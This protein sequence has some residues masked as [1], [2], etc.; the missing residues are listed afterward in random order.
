MCFA[1]WLSQGTL[2][3]L[4]FIPRS[5]I[6]RS[7]AGWGN[8]KRTSEL[9]NYWTP[10]TSG[11]D[12]ILGLFENGRS[13]E[14]LLDLGLGLSKT[15]LPKMLPTLSLLTLSYLTLCHHELISLP[16]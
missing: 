12:L 7:L 10:M 3:T 5:L 4:L 14:W 8:A 2:S 13:A 16:K 11:V 9:R 15:I 6:A 1:G